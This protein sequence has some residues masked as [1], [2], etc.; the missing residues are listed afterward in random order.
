[1]GLQSL[2]YR[3]VLVRRDS[4]RDLI[5]LYITNNLLT[6]APGEDG[7]MCPIDKNLPNTAFTLLI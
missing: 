1:M 4:V 7:I 6:S 2:R 3:L 5:L